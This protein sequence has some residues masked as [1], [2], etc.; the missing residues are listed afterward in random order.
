MGLWDVLMRFHGA[1]RGRKRSIRLSPVL[2]LLPIHSEH[3]IS[4]Q[5]RFDR[6]PVSIQ[7]VLDG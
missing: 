2:L 7:T 1:S 6:A 3:P 5:L 4:R